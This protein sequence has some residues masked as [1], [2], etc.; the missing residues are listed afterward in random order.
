MRI[1]ILYKIQ[2]YYV[3]ILRYRNGRV[4]NIDGEDKLILSN[5]EIKKKKHITR[6]LFEYVGVRKVSK[7]LAVYKK[8]YIDGHIVIAE[9]N[10][11]TIF[12]YP[13]YF[14]AVK[15]KSKTF[16]AEFRLKCRTKL[17]SSLS[18][19]SSTLKDYLNAFCDYI[20]HDH[21]TLWIYNDKTKCFTFV[22]GTINPEQQYIESDT[23]TSLNIVL[24]DSFE[25]ET[26]SP[27]TS[28]IVSF[29]EEGMNSITRISLR[30]GPHKQPAALSFYSRLNDFKVQSQ[31]IK[32][33]KSFAEMKYPEQLYGLS[34]ALENVT[35][36]LDNN[37]SVPIEKYMHVL[38]AN[39]CKEL[40]YEAASV[41]FVDDVSGDL[42]LVS[43]YDEDNKGV[44]NKTVIYPKD[45]DSLTN[46]VLKDLKRFIIVYDLK[47]VDPNS[48]IYD[49]KTS[50]PPT[51]W[52]GVPISHDSKV[53]AVIRVKNKFINNNGE[54]EI[55]AP[56]PSD[57]FNLITLTNIVK[58]HLVTSTKLGFLNRKLKLHDNLSK[59]YRH[60]IRGPIS[61]IV[62]I[63]N[64]LIEILN[65]STLSEADIN[66]TIKGLKDLES[67]TQNLAFVAKTY[68]VE[69][70]ISDDDNNSSK[71][72]LLGDLIIPIE[73]LTKNYYK[74]KYESNIIIDH[75]SLRGAV[76]LGKRELYNMV[77]Y[78]LLDNAG[79]YQ[80][81][82][83]GD[84]KIYSDYKSTDNKIT[85]FIEN[86]G[87]E[88]LESEKDSIF[89]NDGRGEAATTYKIDGSG[90]GLW[91]CSR[92]MKKYDGLIE[93]ESR[94]D[95]V[96]FK[97]T[98]PRG[99]I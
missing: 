69:K 67:L 85:L 46:E 57:H 41:F 43:T 44:P 79:K 59:V 22:A 88:I 52:I 99:D 49:E 38:T 83:S 71:L 26:R 91:L 27:E 54:I 14:M 17:I 12:F 36:R 86:Y 28:E 48:H 82:E 8:F 13:L 97:L 68:N 65:S 35:R 80:L 9:F 73:K 92:I 16:M 25:S 3:S 94:F 31:V 34:R 75:D 29:K 37:L 96:R 77:L 2:D 18:V 93:L 10:L 19:D 33:I 42:R 53:L 74:T 1:A 4:L 60:E 66:K 55:I 76:V 87:L 7:V 32:D 39:I 89:Q 6:E 70:L 5:S 78:A 15:Y 56:R 47:N 72:S 90:I 58:G 21:Y 50:H 63:P 45:S 23:E 51:N 20:M 61:S 84:I 24:E 95:P 64:E 30:L 11:F 40:E 98:F 62:E 81:M